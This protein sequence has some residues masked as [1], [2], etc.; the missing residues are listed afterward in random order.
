MPS[1]LRFTDNGDG[2]ATLA[3]TPTRDGTY[4][5][6]ITA[7]NGVSPDGVQDLTL[8]VGPAEAP[9]IT[10]DDDTAFTLAAPGSFTVT[11]TGFPYASLTEV[12]ALPDGI[13]FTDNG[14][15]T[16]TLAGT[17]GDGLGTNMFTISANNAVGPAATQD[18]TLTVDAASTTVS[19]SSSADPAVVGEAVTLSP[20]WR[21]LPKP[22]DAHRNG[23]LPR[24]DNEHQR[25]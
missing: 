1:G 23:G 12:G 8:T 24:G 6:T 13:T 9:D 10:S 4:P 19:L 16:A 15:G 20:R 2:T 21:S 11:T 14:D 17:P 5:I 7:T 25:L 18:F 22:R 3:G